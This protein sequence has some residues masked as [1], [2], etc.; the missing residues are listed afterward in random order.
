MSKK[1]SKRRAFAWKHGVVSIDALGGMIGPTLFILPDGRA[2]SPFHIAPWWDEPK[3][4]DVGRMI[5]GLR[6]EWP[7]VPFGY[8]APSDEY[9]DAWP[10][11]LEEIAV[12][13]DEHGYSS[14]SDWSFVDDGCEDRISLAI[15]YP[16]E[17]AVERLERVVQPD[18][19]AAALDIS[20][21]IHMRRESC[22]PIALH[23]CFR[24]PRTV[25]RLIL[26]PGNFKT[27]RTFPATVEPKAPIFAADQ[28]FNSLKSVPSREGHIV[29]ASALPFANAGEDLLQLDGINGQF[30][31]ANLD[32]NFRLNFEWDHSVL[33]SALLWYSNRGTSEPPW[34]NRNMCIGIEPI[35]SPFGLSPDLARADNPISVAG[36]ATCVPLSPKSPLTI[37]YRIGVSS[38]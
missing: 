27:G 6:G 8:P 30:A 23:G 32:E 3:T 2:V 38:I 25:G 12:V 33:P 24:L 15:D 7:C 21:T 29:D 14:N 26:E 20:L 17:H 36:I 5:S 1:D 22:E 13:D 10:S 19:N 4:V 16:T 35:C 34:N 28:I 11:Y 18:P 9:P 31:F 37:H